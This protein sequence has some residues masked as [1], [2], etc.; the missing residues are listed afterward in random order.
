MTIHHLIE[1]ID[2]EIEVAVPVDLDVDAW[3]Y[4]REYHF[5]SPSVVSTEIVGHK[6]TTSDETNKKVEVTL[7]AQLDWPMSDDII[8]EE[9][10][11][12]GFYFFVNK[13]PVEYCRIAG[14]NT[15]YGMA[16]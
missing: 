10:I 3:I 11:D 13:E 1:T 9:L 8:A 7:R 4:N 16:S 2:V 14:L 15:E 12:A 6:V 5:S